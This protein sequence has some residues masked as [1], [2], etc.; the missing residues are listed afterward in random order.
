[1]IIDLMVTQSP[2]A[3]PVA[4]SSGDSEVAFTTSTRQR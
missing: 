3:A 1:M 4:G 2:R